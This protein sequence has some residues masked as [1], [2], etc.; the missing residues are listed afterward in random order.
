M[1]WVYWQ[2][3]SAL[4]APRFVD[5]A[6][7]CMK[8][9]TIMW[10]PHH[11]WAHALY[12]EPCMQNYI[13]KSHSTALPCL[14]GWQSIGCGEKDS[15]PTSELTSLYCVQCLKSILYMLYIYMK[16]FFSERGWQ[17]ATKRKTRRKMVLSPRVPKV[18]AG[19]TLKQQKWKLPPPRGHAKRSRLIQRIMF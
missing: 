11:Q 19:S 6:T 9:A 4:R 18:R 13:C 2:S 7:K 3:C 16:P 5:K 12:M 14:Q 10:E 1:V 15:A 8:D 17:S